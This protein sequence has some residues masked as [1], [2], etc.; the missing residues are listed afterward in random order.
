MDSILKHS[1]KRIELCMILTTHTSVGKQT[2]LNKSLTFLYSKV[3]RL[4]L[5]NITY[6]VG[7]L[8]VGEEL[9]DSGD[10]KPC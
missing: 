7:A 2:S 10:G 8:I 1:K 9:K 6:S 3:L 5:E 4:R